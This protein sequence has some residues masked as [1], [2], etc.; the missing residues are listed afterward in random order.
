MRENFE[1]R[2]SP[3]DMCRRCLHSRR[4]HRY[5]KGKSRGACEQI[6]C[7][8]AGDSPCPGFLEIPEGI[9]LLSLW[10][11]KRSKI[12]LRMPPPKGAPEVPGGAA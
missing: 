1:R 7:A 2:Y 6:H 10:K 11:E 8:K 3:E 12:V 9:T 5:R 4:V